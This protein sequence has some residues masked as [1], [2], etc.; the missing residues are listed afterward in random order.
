MSAKPEDLTADDL[1]LFNE[2]SHTRLYEK[3]GAHLV[4]GGCRF[5]VWAPDAGHVSVV[6][7][8][9]DYDESAN[10]LEPLGASGIW[11]GF[12]PGVKKGQTYK[13][14]VRNRDTGNEV[15]KADPYA[16]YAEVPPRSA[17]VVWDLD[18]EW[19]DDDWMAS[20]GDHNRP[21]DPIAIY[22][23]HLGSW[24]KGEDGHTLSYREVAPLLAEYVRELEFTHVEFLPVMEHPFGGSWGYQTTGYFSPTS[25][26]GTP[27]DF[28]F[29]VETLH[30]AGIGVILD[31]VPSHFA[32]DEHGL[33]LFDG[34]HLY[35]HADPRQG[36]HPDWGS[37][38]FNYGRKEVCSFLL[39]SALFWLDRYH[40]D[41]IR[42]DAV[43]S[44]LYLDYSR[45]D[46]E[47]IP[48]R[49][50]GNENLEAI[51]FLRRFN[52]EVYGAYPDVQTY[53]EESTAW[54][55]VSR[56]TYLGG[57]GFGFKWDMGW[58]HDTL[59]Y[60]SMDPIYRRFH[61]NELTFRGLYAFTESYV[62]P[63]S[64]DEVVHGKGSLI[65]KMPGDNWR[66]FANLRLL[67]ASMFGQP[68]KKLLFMGGEIAQWSEWDHDGSVEWSLLEGE[69][70]RGVHSLVA[71][72]AHLYREEAALHRMDCDP[73]GFEW[74]E[75]NDPGSSVLAYLRKGAGDLMLVVINYTPVPRYN[76]RVGVPRNGVWTEILNSDAIDYGGS[77]MGNLGGIE[78]HDS[79][80]HGRPYSVNVTVPPLGA[81]FLKNVG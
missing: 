33:G 31:W 21:D 57:L 52:E 79:G 35:E 64:H 80:S 39:S 38:V 11:A 13:Y 58:M 49:Y 17:S 29:L 25:R 68:G 20:R 10:P 67:F 51:D 28:M 6:G 4:D 45:E 37:Y 30:Q 14:V 16:I 32:T 18:Y 47:W 36:F 48:N 60:L 9:N 73:A 63:L 12:V 53:A 78:A 59:A 76:Y 77:G 66:K 46:G 70:H 71:D 41:G 50:G 5:A 24:R 61:H 65:G 1:Y 22:E 44:M 56:P 81:V 74:V 19:G 43:A 7:D 72:L 75:A 8:F 62:L 3:M 54:P 2:G 55:M 15:Y 23:V 26:F 40:I 69:S 42:V 27:Q 34:T